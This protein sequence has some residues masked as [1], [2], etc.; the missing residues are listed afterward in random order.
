MGV[1]ISE[2]I[3]GDEIDIKSI[4]DKTIAIDGF[5]WL[6]QFLSI[7]RQADGTPL[8]D[9]S[10]NITSHLSGLFY[11]TIKLME[12]NIRPIYVF[13]GK[14]PVFKQKEVERRIDVRADAERKWKESLSAGNIKE[15]RKY[16]QGSSRLT[17]EMISESKELVS[18]MGIPVVQAP[19]E[20]EAGCVKLVESGK[21]YAVATQDYD[22]LLFGAKRIIRNLSITGKRKKGDSY[23]VI[24]PEIILLDKFLSQNGID[25]KQLIVMGLLIGTDYNPGIKGIGPKKAIDLVKMK[26][27]ELILESYD[28]G[29][30]DIKEIYNFF[31][32]PPDIDANIK[33]SKPDNE[34][35]KDILCDRH[36]FSYERINNA[37]N[38]LNNVPS[39]KSLSSFH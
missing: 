15:A 8:M 39:Q 2:L 29:V 7:I 6:Y 19:S 30:D 22:S 11:R 35:I 31:L 3:N 21:A 32:N 12:N 1:S 5:N 23:V 17:N 33:F 20:G 18:A 13:D 34:K 24:N 38:K 25:R 9:L 14:K 16:A 10:G 26:N 36:D 37:L 27:L 4:F 28:W